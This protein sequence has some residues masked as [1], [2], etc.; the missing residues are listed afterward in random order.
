MWKKWLHKILKFRIPFVGIA[1][2]I[3][4][5]IVRDR[6]LFSN[7]A[8]TD[9][10]YLIP[11]FATFENVSVSERLS[12]FYQ[13][14]LIV[15]LGLIII[16]MGLY[17]LWNKNKIA[18]VLI[19]IINKISYF[20]IVILFFDL[21]GFK[22][23]ETIDLIYS[24]IFCTTLLYL[25]SFIFKSKINEN[26]QTILFWIG[27]M[28]L[29]FSFLLRAILFY[30]FKN[31]LSFITGFN[32]LFILII[33]ILVILIDVLKLKFSTIFR[34]SL[35]LFLIPFLSILSNEIYLILNQRDIHVLSSNKF[36]VLGLLAIFSFSIIFN[37]LKRNKTYSYFKTF[38]IY[39]F[40][41]LLSEVLLFNF[42][43][44]TIE[45]PTEMFEL[46]NPANGMMRL[47]A[48]GQI[49][50]L[51]AFSSHALSDFG[52]MPLYSM[53]NGYDG[54]LSFLIY[55]QFT[56][57]IFWVIFYFFLS[58]IFKSG[59]ISFALILLIPFIQYY[60]MGS[61]CLI[62][63][64]VYLFSK[65]YVNHSI[66]TIISIFLITIFLCL[67]KIELGL[68]AIAISFT[69][70]ICYL[71][72]KR[73]NKKVVL[74]L[75]KSILMVFGMILLVLA[76][77][78][79]FTHIEIISNFSQAIS[80]LGANQAHGLP[81]IARNFDRIFYVHYYIFPVISILLLLYYLVRLNLKR[82]S[83]HLFFEL[84]MVAMLVFYVINIQRGLVRHSF[85]ETNEL[86]ISS[87]FYLILVLFIWDVAKL[88]AKHIWMLPVILTA[89][90]FIFRNGEDKDFTSLYQQFEFK[91]L[92]NTTIYPT[93]QKIE[94][95]TDKADFANKHYAD[96]K[97]FMDTHFDKNSTFIDFSNTPMLYFY[98]GRHVP[99]Y[100]NQ[101]MQNTVT[102][103]LQKDNIKLLKTIS[104]PVVVYS[105]VPENWFD[106]TDGVPNSIRYSLISNYIYQNYHPYKV[107]NSFQIWIQNNLKINSDS[108]D[109]AT[110]YNAKEYNLKNY[111]FLLA[112]SDKQKKLT[113]LSNVGSATSEA[114][115][116][117]PVAK[118]NRFNAMIQLVLYK[119]DKSNEIK[120]QY[121]KDSL[122][123]GTFSFYSKISDNEESYLIPISTQYNWVFFDC[124]KF[125]VL[126]KDFQPLKVAQ[127]NLYKMQDDEY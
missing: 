68:S 45:N 57:V 122:V 80:Y 104:V 48:Q 112:H 111:P 105:N 47:F 6:L 25:L 7:L 55:V 4:L 107:I 46:A 127:F 8:I 54:S 23:T 99:S 24:L 62:F 41:I 118:V 117:I 66:K 56:S 15:F 89:V 37:Y 22:Q 83:S 97:N 29:S 63:V 123:L 106:N 84:A 32:L 60:F 21:I 94:R 52:F 34:F 121:A 71:I 39:I 96:F 101:Y 20:G 120:F 13:S 3:S 19:P 65:L 2:F 1:L 73:F 102:E 12:L 91:Y 119:Q 5:L 113:L 10:N 74:D 50:I 126:T 98:T 67:W 93:N 28:S 44:A 103:K 53:L 26:I 75:L 30:L 33:F 124:N 81:D 85:A 92:K 36:Y 40:P 110:F 82:D 58:R 77:V 86:F 18:R 109:S 88:G 43:Q 64:I 9:F 78:F 31:N 69:L 116:N 17:I 95:V 108:S 125:S 27:T 114:K 100:F 35:P 11:G 70:F 38:N 51:E 16:S 72:Y 115:I 90:I 87:F 49:P 14:Y 42:Y 61:Y 76:L 59:L 79:T